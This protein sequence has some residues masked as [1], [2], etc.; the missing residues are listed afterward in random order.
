[1]SSFT[2]KKEL[3]FV[4]TLGTGKFGSSDNNQIILQGFRAIANINK[5]GGQM[6]GELHAR[7]YGVSQTN[8]NAVT[9]LQFQTG[10]LIKNT[11]QIYAIDGDVETLV[12]TGNIINAW[13][14]Y[15][16]MPDVFLQIQAQSQYVTGL[17]SSQPISIKGGINAATVMSRIAADMGLTF[18]N[19]GVD[20]I[21]TDVYLA[22]TSKEQALELARMCGFTLYIDDKVL[23]ITNPYQPRAGLIPEISPSSGLIGYPT[24]DAFGVNFTTLFNPAIL[25]GGAI[26]LTTSITPASGQWVVTS[27]NHILEAEKPNGLWQSQVRG[28]KSGLVAT[29]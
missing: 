20:T 2:N 8:M 19:N 28:N 25:F 21:V 10:F 17:T 29:V 4:I 13:G 18:E 6:M 24:F 16:G 22:N 23:A 3:R 26:K 27:V 12:F 5:A 7:I 9:T 1:M 14:D 15:L 11:V